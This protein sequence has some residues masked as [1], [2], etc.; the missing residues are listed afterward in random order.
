M[1]CHA[2]EMTYV[3][4]ICYA[5]DGT[6]IYGRTYEG[7]KIRLLRKNPNVCFQVESIENMARWKSVIG[8]GVFE[9]LADSE[10]RDKA[11]NVLKDRIGAVVESNDLLR[12]QYWPFF[13][14]DAKGIIFRI[15]LHEKTGRCSDS[16]DY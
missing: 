6:Y 8:W 3:I 7:L 10:K 1:G 9:E 4:P 14:P 11:V 12:S 16:V 13:S 15:H 5:Y 2:D